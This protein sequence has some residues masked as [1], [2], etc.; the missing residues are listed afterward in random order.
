M[1][2]AAQLGV[3]L[4]AFSLDA[5]LDVAPGE[6]VALLG[7]NGAG[8]TTALRA[9]AGLRGLDRGAIRLDGTTL[10]DGDRVFV[11]A[12]DRSVGVVFQD[13]LLFPHLSVRENVAFGLRARGNGRAGART[14]AD[15]WLARVGL[16]DLA[17]R[18]PGQLSGG[19]Q[20][21]VALARALAPSPRVLLLDEPLAALD[22]GTRG[23]VRR[24]LR[25]HLEAYDGCTVLVTHDPVDAYALADRVVVVE[26]GRV[27]QQGSLADVA[28]H[29][30]SRYVA[31]LVGINLLRGEV[32]DGVFDAESGATV[33]VG[34]DPLS[35][36][37][38]FV[39]IRPQ[40]ISLHRTHPEGSQRNVWQATVA[41]IDQQHDRVR[42]R[43]DGALPLVAEITP[44]ALTQMGIRPGDEVWAAVKATEVTAYSR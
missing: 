5:T 20:Q 19:Q 17:D 36:G 38:A 7:P 13:Y 26:H 9:L 4:G 14:R 11:P 33:V 1:S 10:D 27:V 12:E 3:D 41:D 29:P 43:L 18:K 44:G 23:D 32:V 30:R 31:E 8:K 22:A 24:D 40:A 15:E 34:G 42:V 39:A 21:R 25:R 2:L 16:A 28:A 6:V 37:P 35:D